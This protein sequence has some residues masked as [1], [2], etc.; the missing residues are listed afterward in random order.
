ILSNNLNKRLLEVHCNIIEKSV[1][2]INE[3]VIQEELLYVFYY[4]PNNPFIK[5]NSIMYRQVVRNNQFIEIYF[6]DQNGNKV[7]F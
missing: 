3:N 5:V 2:S 4:D 1:S 7:D 6:I